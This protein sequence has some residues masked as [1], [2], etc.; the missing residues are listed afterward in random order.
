[1]QKLLTIIF[2]WFFL[3][4][5]AHN[6]KVPAPLEQIH[7]H[8]D[9]QVYIAGD[10]IWFK[11]YI[12]SDFSPAIN[13]R[14]FFIDFLDR[15]GKIIVSKKLPVIWGTSMGN[16]ALPVSLPQ[17][18]YIIRGYTLNQIKNKEDGFF[19]GI[20]VIN[21]KIAG[22]AEAGINKENSSQKNLLPGNISIK[23]ED[24]LSGKLFSIEKKGDFKSDDL[25]LNGYMYGQMVFSQPLNSD[26]NP[27]NGVI[28]LKDLPSGILHIKLFDNNKRLLA[29]KLTFVNNQEYFLPVNLHLD[30]LNIQPKGRNVFSFEFPDSIVGS[31]SLSITDYD[32][33]IRYTTQNNIISSFLIPS[34]KNF[35][36]TCFLSNDSTKTIEEQLDPIDI[37][38]IPGNTDSIIADEPYIQIKGKVFVN[39]KPVK[40]GEINFLLQTRDSSSTLIIVPVEKDGKFVIDNL[41][42]E[43]TATIFY[44]I[45]NKPVTVIINQDRPLPLKIPDYIPGKLIAGFNNSIFRDSLVQLKANEIY[46]SH[47]DKSFKGKT[48][49]EVFVLSKIQSPASS[50]NKKYTTGLF[51]NSTMA[52]TI[53]FINEPPGSLSGNIFDYLQ[54]RIA[55]LRITRISASAYE[56]AT[57]RSISLTGRTITAKIFLNEMEQE[58]TDVVA[59]IP[60]YQIALVKYFTP[61][62]MALPGVGLS[63]VLAIYTKKYDDIQNKQQA[64]VQYFKYPGYSITNEF[65]PISGD[66]NATTTNSITTLLWKPD[67]IIERSKSYSINFNNPAGVRRFHLILEGFTIDGKLLHLEK[68]INGDR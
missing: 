2:S 5:S 34:Y 52:K 33:E 7:L 10:T 19:R 59:S 64:F 63:P 38:E 22:S 55:G 66:D 24:H 60:L 32:K 14:N 41:I 12:L 1:M 17:D 57:S 42:F 11:V 65:S 18:V 51:S 39:N 15:N 30:T 53:D 4:A 61:G 9:K 68:I 62:Y 40:K 44:Q 28:P 16:I 21:P 47:I 8:L 48:L 37:F 6:S 43:D 35:P 3:Q 67:I 29:Q 36:F 45:N 58:G 50:I 54:G 20:P 25:I 56:L 49:K 46:T 26:L 27:I 23:I 13:S 31:F